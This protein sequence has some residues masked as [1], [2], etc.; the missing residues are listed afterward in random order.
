MSEPINNPAKRLHTILSNIYSLASPTNYALF[1]SAIYAPSVE[2]IDVILTYNELFMLVDET[3]EA[4]KNLSKIETNKK[5]KY[6]N[7]L[8]TIIKGLSNI[9]WCANLTNIELVGLKEK[10]NSSTLQSLEFFSDLLD[11]VL[12]DFIIQKEKLDH[13]SNQLNELMHELIEGDFS[14]ELKSILLPHLEAI[15]HSIR[16]YQIH[17]NDGIREN[18]SKFMGSLALSGYSPK[19]ETEKGYF[20]KIINFITKFNQVA[21]FAK[22]IGIPLAAQYFLEQMKK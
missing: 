4:L 16:Y 8:C 19:N 22:T 14:Q 3:M 7:N 20:T 17:G 11:N 10:I 18:L 9:V 12:D 2:Y 5:Q 21:T 6:I 15:Q 1:S 13:F